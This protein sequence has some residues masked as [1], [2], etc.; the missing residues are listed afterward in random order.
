MKNTKYY[1]LC[2]RICYSFAI[3]LIILL[4]HN[5]LEV[6]E[7][8]DKKNNIKSKNYISIALN[9]FSKVKKWR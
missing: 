2:K 5:I 9:K 4:I 6:K 7:V 1:I 8:Y 3:F